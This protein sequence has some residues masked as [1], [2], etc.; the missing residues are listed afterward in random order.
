[1][2]PPALTTARDVTGHMGLGRAVLAL[3]ADGRRRW[4]C[5]AL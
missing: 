5:H 1:M 3:S 4:R 2:T